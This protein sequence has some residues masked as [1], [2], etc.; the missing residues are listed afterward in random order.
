MGRSH[1][2]EGEGAFALFN[3]T[4]GPAG[5]ESRS[6]EPMRVDLRDFIKPKKVV[7][8]KLNTK[9]EKVKMPEQNRFE[10]LGCLLEDNEVNDEEP[11]DVSVLRSTSSGRCRRRLQG[12]RLS[13]GL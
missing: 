2:G 6:S 3:L 7:T 5:K 10:I 4:D 11:M 8:S 13:Q 1:G 12:F 9:K